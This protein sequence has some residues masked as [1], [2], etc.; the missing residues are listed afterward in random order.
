MWEISYYSKLKHCKSIIPISVRIEGYAFIDETQRK[1]NAGR[2][3]KGIYY[4]NRP[5][6]FIVSGSGSIELK[7][8]DFILQ[9][10]R[11]IIPI[12][13]KYNNIN[14]FEIT[15][16]MRNFIER[17]NPEAAAIVNISSSH[18]K[19]ITN[20]KTSLLPFYKPRAFVE[21]NF[22]SQSSSDT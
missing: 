19:F 1:E 5:Y 7:G 11:Q 21:E 9:K 12:E 15:R 17:Y 8:V 18:E 20:T 6:K 10:G 3:L 13:V 14:T 4:M 22:S 16:A 2:F